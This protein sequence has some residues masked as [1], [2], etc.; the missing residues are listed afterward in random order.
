MLN[1]IYGKVLTDHR[2][3]PLYE[4][5]DADY[6]E[7]LAVKEKMLCTE[8]DTYEYLMLLADQDY[9]VN[10][11]MRS[12]VASYFND[13]EYLLNNINNVSLTNSVSNENS[14]III[15]M[16]KQN[17][18]IIDKGRIIKSEGIWKLSHENYR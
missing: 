18:T 11:E 16:D 14:M 13:F 17:N 6:K 12:M 8:T 3:D 1:D 7:Y 15:V 4:G 2:S 10:V 5:W 9:A